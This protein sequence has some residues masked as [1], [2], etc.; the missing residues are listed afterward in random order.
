MKIHVDAGRRRVE[1]LLQGRQRRHDERLEHGV[2]AS[3]DGE[4]REHEAGTR[5][6]PAATCAS[7]RLNLS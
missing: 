7:T 2:R 3:A 4:H 5:A 1:I 6:V